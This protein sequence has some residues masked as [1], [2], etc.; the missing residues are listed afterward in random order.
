MHGYFSFK[1]YH[2]LIITDGKSK[3]QPNTI[4]LARVLTERQK[5]AG[6]AE[7]H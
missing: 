5:L 6:Y 7:I 2:E 3:L 1:N 4:K